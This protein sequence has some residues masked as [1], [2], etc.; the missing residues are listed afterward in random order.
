MYTGT[1]SVLKRTV[2]PAWFQTP[3]K[4]LRTIRQSGPG[5]EAAGGI[6]AINQLTIT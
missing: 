4:G 6:R 2:Q 3:F 5:Q 1:Q